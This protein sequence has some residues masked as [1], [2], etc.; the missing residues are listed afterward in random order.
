[1]CADFSRDIYYKFLDIIR[2]N[3]KLFEEKLDN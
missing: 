2:A 1:M 3:R